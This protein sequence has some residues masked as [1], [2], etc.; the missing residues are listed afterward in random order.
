[1]IVVRKDIPNNIIVENWTDLT[2]HPYCI[3]LDIK[4]TDAQSGKCLRKTRVINRYDNMIGRGQLWEGSS[5][6]PQQA[7]QD[8]C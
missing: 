8:N 7:I 6:I 4:E 5:S 3:C 2:R 1:M